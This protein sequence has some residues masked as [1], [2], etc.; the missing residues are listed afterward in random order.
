M[1]RKCSYCQKLRWITT[2]ATLVVLATLLY[3]S[4]GA[5]QT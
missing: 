5:N 4:Y 2:L 3:T 1:S